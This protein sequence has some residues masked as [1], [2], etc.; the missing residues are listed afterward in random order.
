METRNI[1]LRG[2][3]VYRAKPGRAIIGGR[4][5]CRKNGLYQYR[6]PHLSDSTS[7]WSTHVPSCLGSCAL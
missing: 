5:A 3:E 4:W 2:L 6:D 7:L 1:L